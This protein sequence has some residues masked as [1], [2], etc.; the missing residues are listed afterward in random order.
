MQ[1]CLGWEEGALRGD[2]SEHRIHSIMSP[3]SVCW[4][5]FMSFVTVSWLFFWQYDC[6]IHSI[7][8]EMKQQKQLH[9]SRQFYIH[10]FWIYAVHGAQGTVGH[11]K[12]IK[13]LA[14]FRVWKITQHTG[15][16]THSRSWNSTIVASSLPAV[17]LGLTRPQESDVRRSF[18]RRFCLWIVCCLWHSAGRDVRIDLTSWEHVYFV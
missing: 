17:V 8:H 3:L 6:K 16:P 12:L 15:T 11:V 9:S 4:C 13:Y 7:S 14:W 18:P 10:D 1:E 5:C 2:P